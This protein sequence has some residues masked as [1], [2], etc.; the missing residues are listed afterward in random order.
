MKTLRFKH[1]QVILLKQ[2]IILLFILLF[3]VPSVY[4]QDEQ[5]KPGDKV[6]VTVTLDSFKLLEDQDDGADGNAEIVLGWVAGQDGVGSNH[7]TEV[8]DD[9]NWDVSPEWK[10]DKKIWE[11]EDCWPMKKV[12]VVFTV[13][14]SDQMTELDTIANVA[15]AVAGIAQYIPKIGKGIKIV[16]VVAKALPKVAKLINGDDDLG[17]NTDSAL[18]PGT[19]KTITKGE[20]GSAEITWTVKIEVISKCP[21]PQPPT[22][23]PSPKVPVKEFGEAIRDILE[24]V[25][26]S[27]MESGTPDITL[28]EFESLKREAPQQIMKIMD[29][30]CSGLLSINSG[31]PEVDRAIE[32]VVRAREAASAR[33]F[34]EAIQTYEKALLT[35]AELTPPTTPHKLTYE[36]LT[37]YVNQ[38]FEISPYQRTDPHNIELITN[39]VT[40]T[41]NGVDTNYIYG[42]NVEYATYGLTMST[43]TIREF[44][45][46]GDDFTPQL[47]ALAAL[48]YS[49]VLIEDAEERGIHTDKHVRELEEAEELFNRSR[50]EGVPLL[51]SGIAKELL[52]QNYPEFKEPSTFSLY[53]VRAIHAET[54]R[55]LKEQLVTLRW[56][57]FEYTVEVDETDST[58]IIGPAG[59]FTYLIP[60][61]LNLIGLPIIDFIPQLKDIAVLARGVSSAPEGGVTMLDISVSTLFIPQE[62]AIPLAENSINIF[63]FL[64]L[65]IPV[66]WRL[67]RRL[68]RK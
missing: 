61:K 33:R 4:P 25:P 22:P 12:I 38:W 63:L 14:E 31:L 65:L 15:G 47:I 1:G 10:I 37:W 5:P 9:L 39:Y 13:V 50:Y 18:A 16:S 44:H 27:K 45:A 29:Y 8:K 67:A 24:K 56:P 35:L 48:E 68:V 26:H 43:D 66:G 62:I 52:P 32:L 53:M 64:F 59:R 36:T 40:I 2:V 17:G 54:E 57:D 3:F 49:R 21:S 42:R 20:D 55:P 6:K 28:E 41:L 11:G 19:Y 23:P 60:I 51:I 30:V 34:E 7:G 58:T 46:M